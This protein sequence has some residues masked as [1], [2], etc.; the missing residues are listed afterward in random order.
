[1]DNMREQINKFKQ[2][3]NEDNKSFTQTIF[4]SED[5]RIIRDKM[6]DILIDFDKKYYGKIKDSILSEQKD[7][8]DTYMYD[9]YKTIIEILEKKKK[10]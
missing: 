5:K 7:N 1:M 3:I 8:I 10:G 4:K 6:D 2:F 9:L